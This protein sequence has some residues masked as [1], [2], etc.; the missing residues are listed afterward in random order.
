MLN[1]LLIDNKPH[2]PV[3]GKRQY[4]VKDYKE[5]EH[6][7]N[8]Y[9]QINARCVCDTI[10]KYCEKVKIDSE[11]YFIFDDEEIKEVKENKENE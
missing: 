9:T 11:E 3:C 4:A 10:F 6:D 1:A 5:V 2:C 7:S 8:K